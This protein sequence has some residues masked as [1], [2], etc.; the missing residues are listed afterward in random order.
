[1]SPRPRLRTQTKALFLLVLGASA[2]NQAIAQTATERP[3]LHL[4]GGESE[5]W[6]K[7]LTDWANAPDAKPKVIESISSQRSARPLIISSAFGWRNDPIRGGTRRHEGID[8]PGRLGSSVFV[9]GP[10]VVSFAGWA[11]GYGNLV[12]IDHP[13]G[14]RTRY[15]HLSR[16]LVGAGSAVSQGEIIGLMGSTGRS[17]GSHLHY[18]VRLGGVPVNPLGFIGASSIPHYSVVW[19]ALRRVTPRWTGWAPTGES[20]TLPEAAI[21]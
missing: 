1:M 8:I 13:G 4:P 16:I 2:P 9:T 12:Q 7:R 19:P 17:T 6:R 5:E 15:G 3:V 21:R 11:K 10:G 14:L 18:E 20:S